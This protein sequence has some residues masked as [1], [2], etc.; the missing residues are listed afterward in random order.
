MLTIPGVKTRAAVIGETPETYIFYGHHT[1]GKTHLAADAAAHYQK[2]GKSVLYV[3]TPGE[4]PEATLSQFGLGEIITS[5]NKAAEVDE[6]IKAITDKVDVVI[7]DSLKGLNRLIMDKLCGKDKMPQDSKGWVPAH[8]AFS[9][10]VTAFKAASPVTIFLCPADRST[11]S[12]VDPDGK[13]PNVIACDLPG[14]MSTA[15]RAT[16]SYM[17]YVESSFDQKTK[18]FTRSASFVPDNNILTLARGLRQPM[19]EPIVFTGFDGQW[20]QITTAL[21]EQRNA[22]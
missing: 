2:L 14:R 13:K 17:A 10:A 1:T 19:T 4:E 5:V 8:E 21:E 9:S 11:D 20:G 15:I 6:L 7:V 16:V 12:F 22:S 18:V 3:V